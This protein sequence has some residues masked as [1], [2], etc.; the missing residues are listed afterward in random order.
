MQI[1]V[2]IP[3]NG[4]C[5]CVSIDVCWCIYVCVDVYLYSYIDTHLYS[6]IDRHTSTHTHIYFSAQG[7][8]FTAQFKQG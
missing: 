1:I 4:Q 2:M 7:V 5:V 8:E 6:Y 3:S